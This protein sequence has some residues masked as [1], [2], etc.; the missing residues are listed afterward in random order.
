[1]TAR[2]GDLEPLVSVR[3]AV[4][5]GCNLHHNKASE[6]GNVGIM[7]KDDAAKLEKWFRQCYPADAV[8]AHVIEPGSAHVM[9]PTLVEFLGVV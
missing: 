9:G 2:H 8:G 1:M 5:A 7:P 6:E 4:L 3:P